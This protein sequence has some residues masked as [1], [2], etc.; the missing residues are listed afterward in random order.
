MTVRH[1]LKS[2]GEAS[3][4][5][6]KPG[7]TVRD[8]AALLSEKRIGTVV[9]SS[10]GAACEGI[11]SERDIVRE[12]GARGGEVLDLTLADIMT[13]EIETCEM[14]EDNRSV[15]NRMTEGRFRHMPVMEGDRMVAL[16]SLGDVVK[17]RLQEVR[18]ERDALT[19]MVMGH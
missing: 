14:G 1:I 9:I 15:L 17:Y 7:D 3:V 4:V 16:I 19:G 2:K 13:R 8:A 5:T 12:L 6:L 18:A 10:D 11:V